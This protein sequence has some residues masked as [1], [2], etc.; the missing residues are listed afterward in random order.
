M[1][2]YKLQQQQHVT[3]FLFK[4]DCM[5]AASH[6]H[7]PTPRLLQCHVENNSTFLYHRL[8]ETDNVQSQFKLLRMARAS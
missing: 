4:R 8:C 3:V 6:D 1:I 5:T 2:Y 7:L